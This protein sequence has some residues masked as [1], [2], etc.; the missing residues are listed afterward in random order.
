MATTEERLASLEARMDRINDLFTLVGEL[1][2]DLD[3]RF[4]VIDRRFEAIDRRFE[5]IDCRFE[6]IDRRFDSLEDKYDRRFD[7]VYRK[8]DNVRDEG[9]R[10][11]RWVVGI[12]LT[13]MAAVVAALI[14][15]FGR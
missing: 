3:R 11:F 6:A 7:E 10:E 4:D 13:T 2:S 5:A 8:I 15:A 9:R 12:Q 1:R 14:T